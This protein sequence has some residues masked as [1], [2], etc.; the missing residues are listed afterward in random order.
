MLTLHHFH[1]LAKSAL[2]SY[3]TVAIGENF[4]QENFFWYV[5]QH[6]YYTQY[7]P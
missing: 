1:V 4:H 5:V 2:N 7:V 3:Y 6:E